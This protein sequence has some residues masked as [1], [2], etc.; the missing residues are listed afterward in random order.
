MAFNK[1]ILT[2][3]ILVEGIYLILDGVASILFYWSQ[4]WW[5]HIGRVIRTLWGVFSIWIAFKRP[6]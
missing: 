6:W 4:H 5:E 1:T 3:L 2:V